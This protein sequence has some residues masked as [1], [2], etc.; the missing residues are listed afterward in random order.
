MILRD[1]SYKQIYPFQGGGLR[2]AL[3][4]TEVTEGVKEAPP[5][6]MALADALELPYPKANKLSEE[7]AHAVDSGTGHTK[8]GVPRADVYTGR[9]FLDAFALPRGWESPVHTPVPLPEHLLPPISS[10]QEV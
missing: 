4:S 9:V 6:P 2:R 8:F 5:P 3:N 10:L 7:T 1:F